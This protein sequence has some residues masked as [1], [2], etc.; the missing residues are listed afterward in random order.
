MLVNVRGRTAH[1]RTVTFDAAENSVLLIEQRL[2]PHEFKIVQTAD[3]RE[4]ARAITDMVVRGAG[5]IGA[6]AAYGFA[7]GARAFRGRDLQ[8]FQAH[9]ETV[10]QTLKAARPTA[11][12]PVNAM[13]Q[14]RAALASGETVEEQQALALAAAE[15]FALE[16]VE[17]CEEIGRHGAKLIR[18]GMNV[19][20]HCNAGWLA[21]VDVGSATAPIYAAQAQGKKFHV[22]CDETR[23]RS[24][25]ATLTAW[26]LAQQGI[27]HQ[28]IADNAAGHLMQRGKIDMV[29][30][31][32]DRTLGRTGEVANKI[33]TYTKAVLAH[34]HKIPFYVAI[35]LSTIDW[36]LKSGFDIPIE[37][38]HESEVLGAW[39]VA[40]KHPSKSS[41]TKSAQRSYVRVANPTSSA[42]N[43]GFDV[44]PAE[45][46]TGIITPAGIFKPSE[47]WSKRDKL[48][49][50][51]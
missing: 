31:G 13:D 22:F 32:S 51:R 17:H 38:R 5:A 48:G 23:P 36:N 15:E 14:V 1:Y 7:Q 50:A 8:K 46:I 26:E 39:G 43:P 47:L 45:L 25:G 40:Q 49:F 34:R 16:D 21:F 19:L 42:L 44:T 35:P 24:Q 33:G 27:S 28:I 20:T 4:T 11:V 9:V 6:T 2:L 3:F 10:Y 30:V 12:D 18:H 37:E 29:I 41:G